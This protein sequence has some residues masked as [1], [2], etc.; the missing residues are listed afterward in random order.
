MPPL[1]EDSQTQKEMATLL[2]PDT[3][4]RQ[5]VE[6]G[7]ED[8]QKLFGEGFVLEQS[9]D[10]PVAGATQ[11]TTGKVTTGSPLSAGGVF[12][13]TVQELAAQKVTDKRNEILN[14]PE[15]YDTQ[16][17][18]QRGALFQALAE[19]TTALTPENL[20]W[21]TPQQQQAIR[22]GNKSVIQSAIIGLN[23]ILQARTDLR[24]EEEARVEKEEAKRLAQMETTF[25]IYN[26]IGFDKLDETKR[27]ELEVSLGLPTGTLDSVIESAQEGELKWELGTD[28]NNN[29]I[30]YRFDEVTGEYESEIISRKTPT[31]GGSSSS[32][33]APSEEVTLWAN[34]IE[35][36]T[37]SLDAILNTTLAGKVQT[38]L[39]RRQSLTTQSGLIT[40]SDGVT[41]DLTS[42]QGV[43]DFWSDAIASGDS[44]SLIRQALLDNG[45]DES[46][47]NQVGG[48]IA[49][50]DPLGEFDLGASIF[51]WLR[52]IEP[53][54]PLPTVD[55]ILLP[56]SGSSI[57]PIDL[58]PKSEP[59]V[60]P[61]ILD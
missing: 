14:A 52:R 9:P 55:P 12:A 27:A 31:G 18:L 44:P 46:L 28:A 23:S 11:A 36:G 50:P 2:H 8:A 5:A 40:T 24:K 4:A 43:S 20:R 22:D 17:A 58:S 53:I 29:I 13:Q 32:I 19:G 61:L 26:T 48:T 59:P 60:S 1:I 42:T 15:N 33:S 6:V 30:R 10:T 7:S 47:V 45:V 41:Y 35:A 21:L 3:G 54:T 16:I 56:G 25:D 38:E 57:L 49:T 37:A 51:D 34:E 39:L